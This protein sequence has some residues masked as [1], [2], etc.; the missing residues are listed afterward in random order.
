M[1]LKSS[2]D[3]LK[4]IF[5]FS[6]F[7]KGQEEIIK[8]ILE[9][10]D[11]LGIMPTGAGKSLCYQIPALAS[12]G[13]SVTIVVSP[14]ISLMKDQVDA[15]RQNG[16]EAAALHSSMD[17]DEVREIMSAARRGW[18]TL[19]YV[20]PERFEH[21]GFRNF[22]AA[23]PVRLFVIDEAHCVSQWGHDF[24]PSYL[25]LANALTLLPQR[26]VVAAFTATATH[27]VRD[28]VVLRLDLKDPFVLTTG[29]DRENL[30]F[31]VKRPKDK[32]VFLLSY[33]KKF[34]GAS[35]IVYCSTRRG[36]EDIHDFLQ[37]KGIDAVR[38]HAGLND[39]ERHR[40]QDAFIYDRSPIM[41]A[42]NAFGMGIDKSNVRYVLHFNMP[43]SIDSYYQEAGRAGRDGDSAE[44]LLLFAPKDIATAL[45]LIRRNDNDSTRQMA[46][47]KLQAMVDYCNTDRCLRATIL[48][49][50]GEIEARDNCA[51]CGNCVSAQKRVDVTTE[52]K[53][54]LS[55]VYRME[56]RT[57]RRFGSGVLADVLRG[58][59]R[60][61][62][63]ALGLNEISTWG[64]MREYNKMEIKEMTDFLTAE[65]YLEVEGGEYP[66]LRFTS[67]TR[68]FLRGQEKI[69]M[70]KREQ[71]NRIWLRR[72]LPH[73]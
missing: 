3:I 46:Y 43:G 54:I 21:D 58:S 22:F 13:A 9:G 34:S 2:G 49:Y 37:R 39:E 35:G 24:R 25:N 4:E 48:R 6:S 52:A 36:V 69:W 14:L 16:I 57:G 18:I 32:S 19:L 28:D 68:P 70:R 40:N 55:C 72:K 66:L 29:V 73:P 38:Y 51:T 23:L 31:Q 71:H 27:E 56:E 63:E 62:I 30:F 8:Y 64:L 60:G 45:F 1:N 41:V 44:C 47:R 53:K 42:T 33:A 59:R 67:R 61:Q 65:G 7:R 50:F 15:L 17:W 5:G 20:A 26:P 12:G 10:Q 11:V